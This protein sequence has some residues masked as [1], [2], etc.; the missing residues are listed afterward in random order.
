[1]SQ[2]PVLPAVLLTITQARYL[3]QLDN[4]QF[5]HY[6]RELA[7]TRLTE[8]GPSDQQERQ[9][10]LVIES[11]NDAAGG[12]I[13]LPMTSLRQILPAL[14]QQTRLPAAPPWLTGLIA[15]NRETIPV[16]DLPA[17]LAQRQPRSPQASTPRLLLIAQETEI[18]VG[19]TVTVIGSLPA[20]PED[21]IRPLDSA[22]AEAM[23]HC[24][25]GILGMYAG[26]PILH[27]PV[28]LTTMVQHL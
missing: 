23:Q 27:L 11:E 21:Q 6:A 18:I 1:M 13:I 20:L 24:T 12:R 17:Y 26:A 22:T 7:D 14:P 28:I 5:W 25:H 9:E 8:D 10:Y 19:L 16:I 2:Y 4:Q 3:E 15:W